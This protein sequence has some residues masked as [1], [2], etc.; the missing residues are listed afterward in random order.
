MAPI[1]SFFG[2]FGLDMNCSQ[3]GGC[4]KNNAL[5]KIQSAPYLCVKLARAERLLKSHLFLLCRWHSHTKVI[6]F[7]FALRGEHPLNLYERKSQRNASVEESE[8]WE[9]ER[10]MWAQIMWWSAAAWNTNKQWKRKFRGERKS[11]GRC[12]PV[13]MPQGQI[14]QMIPHTEYFMAT[15]QETKCLMRCRFIVFVEA[16]PFVNDKETGFCLY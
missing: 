7:V 6:R 13:V 5:Y 12:Y 10:G 9:R 15:R 8:N 2:G 1:S 14:S 16:L 4:I 3:T 11:E